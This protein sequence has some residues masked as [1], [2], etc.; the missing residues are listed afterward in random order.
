MGENKKINHDKLD[1]IIQRKTDENEA[2]KKL[3]LELEKK[4][5][6]VDINNSPNKQ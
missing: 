4:S 2:L 1:K 5:D 6:D 3:I